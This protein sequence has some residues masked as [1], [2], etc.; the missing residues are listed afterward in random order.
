MADILC[1]TNI[2][3]GIH[4]SV[5]SRQMGIILSVIEVRAYIVFFHL[6]NHR[7]FKQRLECYPAVKAKVFTR[8][9]VK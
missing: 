4:Y 6:C 7:L 1:P 9:W 2:P 5:Q 3:N 8:E